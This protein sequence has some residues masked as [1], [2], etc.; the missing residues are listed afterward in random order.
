VTEN[1]NK[2]MELVASEVEK[3]HGFVFLATLKDSG[4]PNQSSLN[5]L[6]KEGFEKISGGIYLS[7]LYYE[8]DMYVFQ[9][10]FAKGVYSHETALYLHN[11]SDVTPFNYTMTFP[12]GY[13]S[14]KIKEEP[15]SVVWKERSVWQEDQTTV[16]SSNGND[17]VV[18][19][20]ERT[21][22]DMFNT[23]YEADEDVRLQAI[24]K[25]MKRADKNIP[26]L[27]NLAKRYNVLDKLKTY[28]EVLL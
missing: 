3:N 10:R 4:Y 19:S 22:C 12:R 26:K 27:L 18:Y 6:K 20:M 8:D 5:Y 23:R 14:K 21:L 24:V 1:Q 7:P 13:H 16:K 2:L 28:V 11:L 9:K 15:I 25:Y 17:I